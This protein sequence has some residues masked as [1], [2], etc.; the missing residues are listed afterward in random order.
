MLKEA[1]KF[2]LY[3]CFFST[4]NIIMIQVTGIPMESDPAPF[5]ANLFLVHKEGDWV[6][7]QRM[8]ETINVWKINN[9]FRFIDDL[10]S[11]NDGSTFENT[12][13][14]FHPTKLELKKEHNCN[15]CASFLKGTLMQIWKSANAF[16]SMW[17]KY[18]DGFT[19]KYLLLFEILRRDIC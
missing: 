7:A 11:L 9:S 5:F 1:I 4:G 15:S 10:L 13:R 19:L 6:K 16:V 2:L 3:N 12:I 14:L 17:K 18:V 8:L